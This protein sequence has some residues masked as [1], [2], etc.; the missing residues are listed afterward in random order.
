MTG[1]HHNK[2]LWSLCGNRNS[3][4]GWHGVSCIGEY[5]H[6]R[7]PGEALIISPHVPSEKRFD[8]WSRTRARTYA[9]L[10]HRGA[11][12]VDYRIMAKRASA[13]TLAVSKNE[14]K[15]P[16]AVIYQHSLGTTT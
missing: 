5:H 3:T 1:F 16:F 13:L 10:L 9:S 12:S 7:A 8:I 4:V 14:V 2:C 15:V 6:V 11:T